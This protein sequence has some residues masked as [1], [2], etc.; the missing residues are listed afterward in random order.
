LYLHLL[1]C[2]TQTDIF[3]K[4]IIKKIPFDEIRFSFLRLDPCFL[5]EQIILNLLKYLPTPD[6]AEKLKPFEDAPLEDVEKLGMPEKFC[7]QVKVA[8][9]KA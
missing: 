7:L 1:I 6:E 2:I 5:D 8:K 4:N 3:I 9:D